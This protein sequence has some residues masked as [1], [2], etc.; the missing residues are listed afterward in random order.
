MDW[1]LEL[2]VVPVSD[3]DRAKAF[4][5]QQMGW[6]V[7]VDYSAN[8]EFRIVQL[9]PPGSAASVTLMRSQ[10]MAPGSLHGLHIIVPDIERARAELA[11]RGVDA[12]EPFH[13]GAAGQ[14]PGLHPTRDNYGTFLSIKDPDGNTL[15]IQEVDRSKPSRSASEIEAAAVEA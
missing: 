5:E 12:G 15:L 9:T 2:V 14:T 7:D 1:T 10:E 4:Y 8:P 3:I 11:A 13:F 6:H